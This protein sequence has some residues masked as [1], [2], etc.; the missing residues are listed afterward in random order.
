[1][2]RAHSESPSGADRL[3]AVY[4]PLALSPLGSPTGGQHPRAN[5]GTHKPHHHAIPH[6]TNPIS[7]IRRDH[8]WTLQFHP[9]GR[10]RR[11][12]IAKAPL[13]LGLTRAVYRPS[14]LSPLGLPT[15]EH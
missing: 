8:K 10:K 11:V 9:H 7:H 15:G 14:A 4:R 12:L 3:R 13:G 1:M 6:H 5:N 2:P